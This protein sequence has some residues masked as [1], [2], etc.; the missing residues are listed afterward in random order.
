[1]ERWQRL[2]PDSMMRL[3]TLAAR[4]SLADFTGTAGDPAAARDQY[5][6]LLPTIE[7]LSGS[8]H[9][10]TRAPSESRAM[11]GIGERVGSYTGTGR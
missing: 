7:E 1:M 11:G 6:A 5:A 8:T 3:E 2:K 9:P 10:D 4:A